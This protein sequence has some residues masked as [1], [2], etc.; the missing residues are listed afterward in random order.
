MV[1][2]TYLYLIAILFLGLLLRLTLVGN[3]GFYEPD[4]FFY[5]A[6]MN[7]TFHNNLAIPTPLVL[8]GFP[9]Q[10]TFGEK[11][12]LIYITAIP[13]LLFSGVISLYDFMRFYPVLFGLLSILAAWILAL[14]LADNQKVALL[15][16][17]IVAILPAAVYRTQA[18]QYRGETF[19]IPLFALML[20]YLIYAIRRYEK[21][22]SKFML[23]IRE[24]FF[25][26]QIYALLAIWLASPY[27][28]VV[29]FVTAFF[30]ALSYFVKN[31]TSAF[32]IGIAIFL[33]IA[34]FTYGSLAFLLP[35]F[36]V[37][38]TQLF[39]TIL[40][41]QPAT[42]NELLVLFNSTL[43]FAP[44]GVLMYLKRGEN[45]FAFH[46]LFA[47][48]LVGSFLLV[49]MIRWFVLIYI[50]VAIFSAYFLIY[51]IDALKILNTK[52]LPVSQIC[53]ICI[54]L[55][56]FFLSFD[57]VIGIHQ[58]GSLY[59]SL[60]D[61]MTWLKHNSYPASTVL[62]FWSDG[63]VIE[64]WANRQSY[65]DSVD[66]GQNVTRI[67]SFSQFL[68]AKAPDFSYLSSVHPDYLLIRRFYALSGVSEEAGLVNDT[69]GTNLALLLQKTHGFYDDNVTLLQV[70]QENDTYLYKLYY[71]QSQA[72]FK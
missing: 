62:A 31:R 43:L 50:P 7:Q 36:F 19:V 63:S 53:M 60:L 6:V 3:Q 51:A 26:L 65:T 37:V 23:T 48:F 13:Y 44:L 11:S 54:I 34:A 49:F 64:G 2:K 12:G 32:I 71:N 72:S 52:H 70:F 22:R 68:Y 30:A 25:A 18:L 4:A 67:I 42:L 55:M 14:Q 16:A 9:S 35:N 57:A 58:V 8:S 46:A 39:T 45:S 41:T 10:N 15:S 66:I 5:Y 59:P 20:A 27:A 69:N 33:L 61:S 29:L 17:F 21:D 40:E 1:A 28:L 56:M 47:N 38:Q 24:V